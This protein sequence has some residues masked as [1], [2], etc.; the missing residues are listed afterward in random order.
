MLKFNYLLII[1][2]NQIWGQSSAAENVGNGG[3]EQQNA[4]WGCPPS[5]DAVAN[6]EEKPVPRTMVKTE[7][8]IYDLKKVPSE[9]GESPKKLDF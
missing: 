6:Y 9:F 7:Q 2:N 3:N 4:L 1:V 5:K 8:R